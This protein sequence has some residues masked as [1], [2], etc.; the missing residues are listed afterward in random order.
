[1]RDG[2]GGGDGG[3]IGWKLSE[4]NIRA[5]SRWQN[6][7]IGKFKMVTDDV[8][9]IRGQVMEYTYIPTGIER[10][11]VWMVTGRGKSSGLLAIH[12]SGQTIFSLA[13]VEGITLG[14]G[15]EADEVAGFKFFSSHHHFLSFYS[16][17]LDFIV[18]SHEVHSKMTHFICKCIYY[19][20]SFGISGIFALTG[21]EDQNLVLSRSKLCL[22][23]TPSSFI[24]PYSRVSGDIT[25][26]HSPK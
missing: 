21:R 10:Q 8:I 26:C 22:F 24:C 17:I 1:M 15:E 16:V 25:G 14:A 20:P 11:L 13:H 3:S 9:S 12:S 18:I 7:L 6:E 23:L 5:V 19:C 2:K 4:V